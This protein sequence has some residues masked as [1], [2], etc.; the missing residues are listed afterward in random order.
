M[1][2]FGINV[3][4]MTIQIKLFEIGLVKIIIVA[5]NAKEFWSQIPLLFQYF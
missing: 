2:Y 5:R 3:N 4:L 1:P